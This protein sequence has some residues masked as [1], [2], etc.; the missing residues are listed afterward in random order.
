MSTRRIQ[1]EDVKSEA[2]LVGAG[3]DKT[4]LINDTKIYVT[5]GTEAI[6]KRLDEAIQDGDLGRSIAV[7]DEGS[8]VLAK[9]SSINFVGSGVTATD[10][11]G[12][13]VNVTISSGGTVSVEDEGSVVVASATTLNFI[14]SVVSAADAGGGQVDITVSAISSSTN[15]T[16]DNGNVDV[17]LIPKVTTMILQSPDTTKWEIGITTGGLLTATSGATGTVTALK[18]TK[19]DLSEASFGI[20]NAGEI[21]VTSPP[22][23]GETLE[24]NLYLQDSNTVTWKV[25]VNNADEIV[26]SD[27]EGVANYF[28]VRNEGGDVLFQ[29]QETQG[30]RG[31][32]YMPILTAAD[33]PSTPDAI[34]G[35]TPWCM[36]DDGVGGPRPIFWDTD[37]SAWLYFHNN[38]TV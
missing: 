19:P 14:G 26:T 38:S 2:D 32:H 33:L 28:R 37:V 5:G 34:A 25:S 16:G 18:V 36:Y 21:T 12:G 15:I 35:T 17:S 8:T 27:V 9:P 30:G 1:N 3:A 6:N 7:K 20:T 10:A 23:G 24:N 29:V 11:G 4:R 13:Q 22:S 31:I